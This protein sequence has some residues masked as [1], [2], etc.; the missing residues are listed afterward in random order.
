VLWLLSLCQTIV[1]FRATSPLREEL[2][3]SVH[4]PESSCSFTIHKDGPKGEVV[5]GV[6]LDSQLYYRISCDPGKDREQYCLTVTNCTVSGAGQDPYPIIDAAGCTL[7]PWLF[8]H[9]EYEDDFTA[10]IHNP[11]PVRFRGAS[12]KVRFHCLTSLTL[13]VDGKCQRHVC[14]WNEY[15]KPTTSDPS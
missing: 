14:T 2:A 12:G 15:T 13:R 8:E 6:N 7:E 3:S 4:V 1:G 5:S 10:G 11:T 9:V